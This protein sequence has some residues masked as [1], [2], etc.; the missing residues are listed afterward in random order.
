MMRRIHQS[1]APEENP[2]AELLDNML[3]VS[4]ILEENRDNCVIEHIDVWGPMWKKMER[5]AAA[6]IEM[7]HKQQQ[8][9]EEGQE[10]NESVFVPR[11]NKNRQPAL[12]EEELE[13]EI[14]H[15]HAHRSTHNTEVDYSFT[16]SEE[17]GE[18]QELH[19]K[20]PLV[21]RAKRLP[22]VPAQVG[23]T[24]NG[25]MTKDDVRRIWKEGRLESLTVD[26]LKAY[27]KVQKMQVSGTKP[28]LIKRIMQRLH[29]EEELLVSLGTNNLREMN[30]SVQ[31]SAFLIPERMDVEMGVERAPVM[32]AMAVDC[33]VADRPLF[34]KGKKYR[35]SRVEEDDSDDEMKAPSPEHTN[36]ITGSL[37]AAVPPKSPINK[38]AVWAQN[39]PTPQPRIS[40]ADTTANSVHTMQ[41][42]YNIPSPFKEDGRVCREPNARKSKL[43]MQNYLSRLQYRTDSDYESSE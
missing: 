32:G 15:Y 31:N 14:P 43:I 18:E 20:E 17:E 21:H 24:A 10:E 11:R 25:T 2:I 5:R 33:K 6:A 13:S 19:T 12:R 40:N 28:V 30:P 37:L 7:C 36:H 27:L 23:H 9:E 42:A 4:M 41:A 3:A 1:E 22:R 35:K 29:E 26:R 16:S 34:P 38:T 39:L 8:Q